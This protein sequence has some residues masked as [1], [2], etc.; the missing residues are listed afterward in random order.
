MNQILNL[1]AKEFETLV[2][3]LLEALGFEETEVTG[4][5]HDGGVDVTGELN[6]SNLAKIKVFVQAKRYKLN[7]KVGS[8]TVKKLRSSIPRTGQGIFI[9]TANYQKKAKDVALD[10]DFPR[11]GLINGYQLVDLLIEH[12][13]NIPKEFQEKLGLRPGL[14]QI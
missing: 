4:K 2:S 8:N 6:V 7:A 1:N 14:V 11:I 5:P 3:Y 12:W 13:D 10:P 9:T